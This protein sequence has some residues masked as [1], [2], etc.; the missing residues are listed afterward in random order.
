[1]PPRVRTCLIVW[2]GW[3]TL[4]VFLAVSASLTYYSV[5]QAANW[6]LSLTRS[7]AEW[8]LWAVLTPVV[9]WVAA[10]WPLHGRHRIRHA[11]GHL[12]VGTVVAV[13]KT[14]ADRAILGWLAGVWPYLLF[15]TVALQLCIYLAIVAAAHMMEYYRRSRERDQLEA[16]LAEARL[17][18]LNMQLQPHFLFNTLNTIAELVHGD[19]DIADRMITDLSELLRRTMAMGS[20]PDVTIATE[21]ELL[22]LYLSLQRARFGDRLRVSM[23][24]D[25][26]VRNA[27]VPMLL[28]QPIVENAV[29]HGLARHVN[30]GA[31]TI[32]ARR[33]DD[34][35]VVEVTDDGPGVTDEGV[36]EGIGLTN[37]RARL[38]AL[39]P[40]AA[41]LTLTNAEGGG[42]RVSLRLP[43]RVKDERPA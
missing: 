12:A 8:W 40:R 23:V 2:A 3:T 30:A 36:H 20:T 28:L 11:I 32:A 22:S 4:A 31:I 42:A 15:S 14:V 26:A 9:A 24:I 27:R 19:A 17:Q 38:E 1:M 6:S 33:A 29:R 16:R 25:D 7:L 39:Y 35:L 18:V 37:T 13:A 41:R 10:R 21:L 5:G 43:F 34:D